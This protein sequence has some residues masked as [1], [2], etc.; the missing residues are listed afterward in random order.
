MKLINRTI[1]RDGGTHSYII[2]NGKLQKE[3]CRDFRMKSAG[4]GKAEYYSTAGRWFD[5]YPNNDD[6]NL[7]TDVFLI[8]ELD[9]SVFYGTEMKVELLHLNIHPEICCDECNEVFHNHIDCPVC[10]KQDSETNSFFNLYE[11]SIGETIECGNCNSVFE[12]INRDASFIN[13]W[14]WKIKEI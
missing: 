14:N 5:G 13:D 11:A 10:K 7:I 8:S 1:Y 9:D 2:S 6:S 3:Y 12:L 4:N